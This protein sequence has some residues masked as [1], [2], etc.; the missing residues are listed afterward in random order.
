MQMLKYLAI[1]AAAAALDSCSLNFLAKYT[2]GGTIT[3]LVGTGL[4][5]QINSGDNLAVHQH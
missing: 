4:V 2:V 1:L 3:G 5:L